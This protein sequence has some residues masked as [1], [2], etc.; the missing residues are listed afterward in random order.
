MPKFPQQVYFVS[1]LVFK[2][3]FIHGFISVLAA[4]NCLA[5]RLCKLSLLLLCRCV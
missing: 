5:T 4:S 2:V 3:L 1:T